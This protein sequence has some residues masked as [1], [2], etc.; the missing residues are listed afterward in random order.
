V[1]SYKVKKTILKGSRDIPIC[2]APSATVDQAA[3][4]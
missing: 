1:R 4:A 2:Q 3:D